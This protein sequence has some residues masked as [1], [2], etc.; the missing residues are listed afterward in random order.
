MSEMSIVFRVDGVRYEY[1]GSSLLVAEARWIKKNFGLTAGEFLQGIGSF[2]ADALAALVCI[3]KRR[4]GEIVGPEAVD[5][6][7]LM[8]LIT[9]MN[10]D[11]EA[12]AEAPVDAAVEPVAVLPEAA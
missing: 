4:A 6:L 7:D 11:D 8:Q 12:R 10:E 1:D 3:A 5:N 9:S 2:D